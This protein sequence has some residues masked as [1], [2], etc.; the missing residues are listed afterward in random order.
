MKID[1]E[2]NQ[3][4]HQRLRRCSVAPSYSVAANSLDFHAKEIRVRTPRRGHTK[5]IV[6]NNTNEAK[7]FPIGRLNNYDKEL[8]KHKGPLSFAS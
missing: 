6:V 8:K 5:N 7:N 2:S 3:R 4:D 1:L